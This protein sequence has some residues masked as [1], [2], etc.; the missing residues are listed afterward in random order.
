[1]VI[2]MVLESENLDF[3]FELFLLAKLGILVVVN[4]AAQDGK[5]VGVDGDNLYVK[6]H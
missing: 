2:E 3:E 6:D 5:G 4:L 1:M